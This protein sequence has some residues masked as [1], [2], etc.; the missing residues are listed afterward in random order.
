MTCAKG[1]RGVNAMKERGGGTGGFTEKAA[2]LTAMSSC[3]AFTWHSGM[4]TTFKTKYYKSVRILNFE[5]LNYLL[6][7]IVFEE[8]SSWTPLTMYLGMKQHFRPNI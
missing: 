2:G 7:R 8:M 6:M 1:V 5:D 4:K 3:I